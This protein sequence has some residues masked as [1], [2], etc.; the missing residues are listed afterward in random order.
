[1]NVD[2]NLAIAVFLGALLV[3]SEVR[4]Y[5]ERKRL[6]DRIMSKNYQEYSQ[7]EVA[8]KKVK[9][10]KNLKREDKFIKI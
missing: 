8:E 5:Y 2:I 6:M 9:I 1:M 3:L 7:W 10:P 4:G